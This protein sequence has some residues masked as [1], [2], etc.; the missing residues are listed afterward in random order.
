MFCSAVVAHFTHFYVK[1][2]PYVRSCVDAFQ[3]SILPG[4]DLNMELQVNRAFILGS[5]TCGLTHQFSKIEP[6]P[7]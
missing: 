3:N 5:G 6:K 2:L 4:D 7:L 1:E